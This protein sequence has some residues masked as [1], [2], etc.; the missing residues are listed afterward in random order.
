VHGIFHKT[1]TGLIGV[2][3]RFWEFDRKLIHEKYSRTIDELE[4]V[5]AEALQAIPTPFKV[6]ES[7]AGGCSGA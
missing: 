3:D 1:G 5:R 2:L 4:K 6:L 7:L